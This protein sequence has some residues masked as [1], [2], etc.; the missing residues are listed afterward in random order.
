MCVREG[1]GIAFR[2]VRSLSGRCLQGYGSAAAASEARDAGGGACAC[3]TTLPSAWFSLLVGYA[4]YVV[5]LGLVLV[6]RGLYLGEEMV[7]CGE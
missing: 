4:T 2:V 7:G 6:L 1:V 3:V 5:T